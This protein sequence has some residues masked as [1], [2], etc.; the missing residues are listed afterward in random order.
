M[1]T[2]DFKV[3]DIVINEFREQYDRET[4]KGVILSESKGLYKV[5]LLGE[6]ENGYYDTGYFEWRGK[7]QLRATNEFVPDIN[8]LYN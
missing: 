4:H 3:G 1:R 8:S 5:H 6:D 7:K 2:N